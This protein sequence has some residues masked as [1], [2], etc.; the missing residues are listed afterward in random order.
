[1]I[2]KKIFQTYKVPFNDLSDNAKKLIQGWKR[3]NPSY[4]YHYYSD[5]DIEDFII[6][7]FDNQWYERYMSLKY[8]VMKAD[9][10]R[11]LAIYIYGGFYVDL[12]MKST[13]P[14]RLLN[15]KDTFACIGL[16]NYALFFHPFFGFAAK[17]PMM[18]YLVHSLAKSIDNNKIEDFYNE[19]HMVHQKHYMKDMHNRDNLAVRYVMDVTGPLWWSEA[20]LNY[21]GLSGTQNIF[22]IKH[23]K[24]PVD[25]KKKIKNDGIKIFIDS[26]ESSVYVNLFGSE[27]NFYGNGYK[28]WYGVY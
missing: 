2:P 9:V 20:I 27:N 26:P 21:L 13:R 10:F 15:T 14:I 4:E 8:P 7:Y 23:N 3:N 16:H 11:V 6:Q 22:K 1:M 17:H 24:I 18:E 12:D 19:N 28:S 5:Q 25:V